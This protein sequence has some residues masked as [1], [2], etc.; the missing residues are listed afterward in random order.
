MFFSPTR[1]LVIHQITYMDIS[2][3]DYASYV[4]FC[5][6]ILCTFLKVFVQARNSSNV[7]RVKVGASRSTAIL[8]DKQPPT[9]PLMCPAKK[10][11]STTET[12][13]ANQQCNQCI[14][15]AQHFK[16]TLP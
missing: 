4:K 2:R 11:N 5:P 8:R 6:K 1:L 12:K 10:K 7:L 14:T 16:P 9:A 13:N 15:F 3:D